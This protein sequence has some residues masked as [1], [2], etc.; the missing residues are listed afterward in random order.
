MFTGGGGGG[1]G[2]NLGSKNDVQTG[3]LLLSTLDLGG[4]PLGR[5]VVGDGDDFCF[6]E[7]ADNCCLGEEDFGGRPLFLAGPDED[8][9]DGSEV[10]I[11]ESAQI[12]LFLGVLTDDGMIEKIAELYSFAAGVSY[13]FSIDKSTIS[14]VLLSVR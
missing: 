8:D 10:L 12:P 9:S 14:V 3:A 1:G 5:L 11:L 7:E 2:G 6:E 13:Y 4:R